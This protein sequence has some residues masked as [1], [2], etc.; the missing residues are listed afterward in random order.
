MAVES[1]TGR[2]LVATPALRDPNFER[3]VVLLLAHERGGALGVVLNR[4]TEMPV[5]DIEALG[6]WAER[7]SDPGVVFEGGPVQPEAAIC[8]ARVRPERDIRGVTRVAGPVCSVNLPAGPDDVDEGIEGVRVFSGYAGWEAGQLESE[9]DT[10]S[11][12]VFDGLPGD[13]FFPRPD[14]LWSMVLR[15]QGGLLAAIALFPSDPSLN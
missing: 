6:G 3:T 8:L 7:A 13:A 5:S 12:L 10:G 4:A 2:L 1:L 14:D 11:W 9:I 15:R